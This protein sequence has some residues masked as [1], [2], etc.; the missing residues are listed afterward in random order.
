MS[1]FIHNNMEVD[2]IKPFAP[3]TTYDP[4]KH[5]NFYFKGKIGDTYYWFSEIDAEDIVLTDEN[6]NMF[7]R[8][9]PQFVRRDLT[10]NTLVK[11]FPE[12]VVR[13]PY[14]VVYK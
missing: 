3:Q 10:T 12:S 13:K 1:R 14:E 9:I 8:I 11:Q 7:G 6:L 4:E 2:Y 5:P